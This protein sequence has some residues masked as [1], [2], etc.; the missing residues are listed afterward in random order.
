MSAA[1]SSTP[2]AAYCG[3]CGDPLDARD[4]AA[5]VRMLELEPPRYCTACRRRMVVQ[6]TPDTWTARCA[7]HG[8]LSASTWGTDGAMTWT[9][10]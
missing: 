8:E 4:H 1:S 6:V 7:E 5:C 3:H 2:A 9:D 10:E